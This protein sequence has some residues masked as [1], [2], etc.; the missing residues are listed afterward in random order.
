MGLR[1]TES[2]ADENG[3]QQ[4][5]FSTNINGTAELIDDQLNV[6]TYENEFQHFSFAPVQVVRK[7]ATGWSSA[8]VSAHV[9]ACRVVGFIRDILMRNSI[10]G[11]GMKVISSINCSQSAASKEWGNAAWIPLKQHMVY[12]QKF[13]R[14]KLR[15]YASSLDVVAHEIFHGVTQHTSKLE[16]FG[17]SGAL[18]ESFS[19]IFGI[20]ISNISNQ[21]VNSWNWEL[22]EE[23]N[24]TPIRSFK[25][26]SLF[27]Q[28]EHMNMFEEGGDVHTNSGIHNKAAYLVLTAQNHDGSL[29]FAPHQ[30]A[31]LY[32]LAL[33]RLAE[34][35]TFSDSYLSIKLAAKSMF[36]ND[37]DLRIKLVALERSFQEVGII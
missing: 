9:N 33:V 29:I 20:I 13:S 23:I 7:D 2:S 4:T 14:G 10:D 25:Q 5:F 11:N 6:Y 15:S 1:T 19:D 28:P 36:P 21:N 32:Y 8:A 16:Y 17:E 26:P 24:G 30:V 35:S 3:V 34:K 12:G 31:Q 22:G 18:N 27:N 37:R